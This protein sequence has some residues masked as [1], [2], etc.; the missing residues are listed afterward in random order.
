MEQVIDKLNGL[1]LPGEAIEFS[2]IEQKLSKVSIEKLYNE[3][4]VV[5]PS[6]LSKVPSN[7]VA[8][9][10]CHLKPDFLDDIIYYACED[11]GYLHEHVYKKQTF[12]KGLKLTIKELFLITIIKYDVSYRNVESYQ[13]LDRLVYASPEYTKD[14]DSIFF[15]VVPDIKLSTLMEHR[16]DSEEYSFDEKNISFLVMKSSNLKFFKRIVRMMKYLKRKEVLHINY[17]MYYQIVDGEEFVKPL[18]LDMLHRSHKKDCCYY[19]N[20]WVGNEDQKSLHSNSIM[21]ILSYIKFFLE[22]NQ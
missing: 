19:S 11:V 6:Q 15:D 7:G 21:A 2:I 17:P 10:V 22:E 16:F 4:T 9:E 3:I 12:E 13:F 14:S 20:F 8:V 5:L 1:N 18:A